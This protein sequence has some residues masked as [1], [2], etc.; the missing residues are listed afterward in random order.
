VSL[1]TG[2]DQLVAAAIWE[3][4]RVETVLEILGEENL[5]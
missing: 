5:G 2:V 1:V 4:P 3:E